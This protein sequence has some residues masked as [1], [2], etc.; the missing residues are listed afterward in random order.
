M[1]LSCEHP[2]TALQI[3]T[4]TVWKYQLEETNE[5]LQIKTCLSLKVVPD[6]ATISNP[7]CVQ[8]C[9]HV[10]AIFGPPVCLLL[11]GLSACNDHPEP[12]LGKYGGS[13]TQLWMVYF[14]LLQAFHPYPAQL[15]RIFRSY[16]QMCSL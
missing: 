8:Q 3:E 15:F 11:F 10:L 1:L 7:H 6:V 14:N 9:A 5:M 16:D 12:L 13:L 2:H 4:N